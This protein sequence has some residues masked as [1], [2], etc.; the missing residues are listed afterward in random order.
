MGK[1]SKELEF[2]IF[3]LEQYASYKNTS[4]DLVL[5]QWDEHNITDFIYDMYEMYHAEAIEN[6]F[7]DI[8]SLVA[9]GKPAW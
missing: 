2:F 4:G 9:T 5:K 3:L 6:A 1:I 7:A 8:D